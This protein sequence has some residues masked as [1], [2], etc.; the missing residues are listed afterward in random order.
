MPGAFVFPGGAVDE[1]D[2]AYARAAAIPPLAGGAAPE[3]A[4]AALRELFEE[5]GILLARDATGAPLALG[6]EELT[7]LRTELTRGDRFLAM[8]ARHALKLDIAALTY[9]SNWITPQSEPIRFDAHFFI[10][11]APAD[12]IAVADAVEVHDGMWLRAADALAAAERGTLSLRFP[13]RKHLERLAR[14]D[15]LD[16]L[17]AHVRTRVVRPVLPDDRGDG[18]FVFDQ[19]GW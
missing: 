16:D 6:D 12:Q 7:A 15:A 2:R 13:T 3:I 19:D 17:F 11:R 5:A 1:E 4:V 18:T 10:A 9:Y 14:Y 8:L